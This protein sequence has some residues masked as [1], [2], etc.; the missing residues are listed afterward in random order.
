MKGFFYIKKLFQE[1]F[2]NKKIAYLLK[3]NKKHKF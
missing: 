3:F 2:E 1:S